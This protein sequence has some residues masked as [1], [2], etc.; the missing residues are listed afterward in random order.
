MAG[1][2]NIKGIDVFQSLFFCPIV[3]GF[4]LKGNFEPVPQQRGSLNTVNAR[5]DNIPLGLR[6]KNKSCS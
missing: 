1:I 4:E 3:A 2:Q 5:P 6:R